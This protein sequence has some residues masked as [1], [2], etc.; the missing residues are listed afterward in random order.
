VGQIWDFW[1]E[2]SRDIPAEIIPLNKLP[3][4]G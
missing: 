1:D 2:G 4:F 3:H